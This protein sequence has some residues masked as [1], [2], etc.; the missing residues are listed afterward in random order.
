MKSVNRLVYSRL[1]SAFQTTSNMCCCYQ[2]QPQEKKKVNGCLQGMQNG[3]SLNSSIQCQFIF[4]IPLSE[5][6][7]VQKQKDLFD[8]GRVCF[9][10]TFS[11][12]KIPLWLLCIRAK[13][14][15]MSQGGLLI[16]VKLL[17]EESIA[18]LRGTHS[19]LT[20]SPIKLL[21]STGALDPSV[22]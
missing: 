14:H 10:S 7:G 8:R 20:N 11:I 13:Q 4:M 18:P 12:V 2:K 9:G 3:H 5:Q 6:D 21:T 17:S 1:R 16:S 15:F 22:M 19:N